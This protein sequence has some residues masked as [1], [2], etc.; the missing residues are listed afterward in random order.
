MR[1][2]LPTALVLSGALLVS[3]AT[4]AV[5]R[6]GVVSTDT[7]LPVIGPVPPFS[8]V[9]SSGQPLSE[10]QLAGGVWI[11]DVIFTH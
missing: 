6:H 11:A 5:F 4:W 8:L 7:G 3:A 10:A 9:D 2:L 1:R